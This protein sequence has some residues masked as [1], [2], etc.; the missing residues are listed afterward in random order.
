MK[1]LHCADIHLDAPLGKDFDRAKSQERKQEILLSFVRMVK[2]AGDNGVR[3]IIIA[4]DLFDVINLSQATADVVLNCVEK[5]PDIDF[6]YM[7]GPDEERSYIEGIGTKPANLKFFSEETPFY[8]YGNCTIY[9]L[10]SSDIPIEFDP[11]EINIVVYYGKVNVDDWTDRNI[12]YLAA[13]SEHDHSVGRIDERGIICF[14]GSMECLSF[15]EPGQKGFV[16]IDVDEGKV[17]AE[18]VSSGRRLLNEL[19]LDI[20]GADDTAAVDARIEKETGQIDKKN[21]LKITLTGSVPIEFYVDT[22]YLNSKYRARFYAFIIE[23]DLHLL[24]D[25]VRYKYDRSLRGEFVRLV[26]QSDEP[27]DIKKNILET[28]MMALSGG[29]IL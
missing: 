8:K 15:H 7:G 21:I 29:D 3:V 16:K 25:S 14:P 2:Y 4:G 12:D 19:T 5:N 6:I 10:S 17:K 27:D 26:L 24:K 13:G 1:I 11:N 20:T 22:E 18:F 23:E 28:G 9:G